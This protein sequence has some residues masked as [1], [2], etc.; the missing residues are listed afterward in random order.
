MALQHDEQGF[1]VGQT[2]RDIKKSSN[3]STA[4]LSEVKKITSFL[5]QQGYLQGSNS[6]DNSQP[7]AQNQQS[8]Q[9]QSS[10]TGTGNNANSESA[11]NSSN[12][13]TGNNSNVGNGSNSS[14]DN[15]HLSADNSQIQ[16]QNSSNNVINAGELLTDRTPSNQESSNAINAGEQQRLRDD[17]GRFIRADNG[18]NNATINAGSSERGRN[19][20]GQ[21]SSNG[22]GL[23][24]KESEVNGRLGGLFD[25]LGDRITGAINAGQDLQDVDPT[26]KAFQEV[27]E[28]LQRGFSFLYAGTEKKDKPYFAWFGKLWGMLKSINKNTAD[29][30]E[31]DVSSNNIGLF[32]WA[33]PL[34]MSVLGFIFSPIALGISTAAL[35]AWGIFSKTGREFFTNLGTNIATAWQWSIDSFSEYVI[36]ALIASWD[37][38]VKTF[39]EQIAPILSDGWDWFT[40]QANET[41]V[42]LTDWLKTELPS[43]VSSAWDS[44]TGVIGDQ[45]H[46][47]LKELQPVFDSIGKKWDSFMDSAKGVW[48]TLISTFTSLYNGLKEL[49]IIGDAIKAAENAVKV[50][51]AAAESAKKSVEN[52]V[53]SV[54][55]TVKTA[56]NKTVEIGGAVVDKVKSVHSKSVD[57]TERNVIDPVANAGKWVLGQ[58]SKVFESGKGGAGTISSGKGDH[59]G[60]SYGT[61]QLSSSQGTLKKFLDSSKYGNEFAGMSAGSQAFNN[62]WKQIANDD[63]NFGVEQHDFIKKTHF[64]PQQEMLR[65]NG[66]DLSKKGAAV[67]DSIWSTSTQFGGNTSLIKNA[68]SGKDTDTMSDSE[69]VSAIQDYKLSNND[70]LFSKSSSSVRASTAKRAGDEK[71]KLLALSG[72]TITNTETPKQTIIATPQQIEQAMPK[73]NV[74]TVATSSIQTASMTSPSIAVKQSKIAD[75]PKLIMPL[76]NDTSTSQ[77]SFVSDVGQNLEDFRLAQIAAPYGSGISVKI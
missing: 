43:I 67:Q 7:N 73:N 34:L 71:E 61:Y 30:A 70:R 3:N 22:I 49:P 36:P 32:G 50:A 31:S 74:A 44:I 20:R 35:A 23:D 26:I 54:K 9:Q 64:D 72:V 4:I 5:R 77:S 57:W 11:N 38:A 27:A 24:K 47:A 66:I 39:N 8:I 25:G 63:T 41:W 48:D 12:A 18:Q 29:S 56:Y 76:T 51:T 45:W 60:V 75:M 62:K 2:I 65:R 17:R 37:F 28:P 16:Q 58:T 52:K 42:G 19:S 55:S 21:F 13:N 6:S 1:L 53:D 14:T 68:L 15:S 59:G 10:N 46:D 40:Q 69:I 33:V